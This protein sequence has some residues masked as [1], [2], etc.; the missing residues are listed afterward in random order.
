MQWFDV[1]GVLVIGWESGV[2]GFLCL[3]CQVGIMVW[4]FGVVYY[5]LED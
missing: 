3:G 1:F 2:V 5:G 4:K